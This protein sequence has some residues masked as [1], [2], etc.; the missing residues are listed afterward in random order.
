MAAAEEPKKTQAQLIAESTWASYS[1]LLA[2]GDAGILKLYTANALG[3]NEGEVA[4]GASGITGILQKKLANGAPKFGSISVSGSGVTATG[5]V[6]VLIAGDVTFGQAASRFQQILYLVS[7]TAVPGGIGIQ[8]DVYRTAGSTGVAASLNPVAAGKTVM[9]YITSY[10]AAI[11]NDAK[12]IQAAYRES[13]IMTVDGE[14]IT[15]GAAIVDK[16]S[17]FIGC[18]FE[19]QTA[20]ILPATAD[21]SMFLSFVGGAFRLPGESNALLF[22]RVMMVTSDQNGLHLANDMFRMNYS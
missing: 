3:A 20:D 4:E 13:S 22:T 6:L 10:Y 2:K 21:G 9:D 19:V 17:K 14:T 7:D 18:T 11:Q 12:A 8:L 16:I 5:G 1:Q 15:G